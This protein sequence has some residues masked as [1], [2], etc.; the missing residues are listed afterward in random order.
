MTN[1]DMRT[2]IEQVPGII[3]SSPML[4]DHARI[5]IP[6]GIVKDTMILGLSPQYKQVR[7][8]SILA[9]STET[10]INGI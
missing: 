2:V 5:S 3:A 9:G 10:D 8:L 7:N 4:E 6:G 1:D